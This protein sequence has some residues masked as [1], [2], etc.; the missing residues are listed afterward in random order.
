MI[1]TYEAQHAALIS[2][3]QDRVGNKNWSALASDAADLA[4]LETL[5][6]KAPTTTTHDLATDTVMVRP[7]PATR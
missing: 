4:T 2:G 1:I 3:L 6:G 5:I 7:L